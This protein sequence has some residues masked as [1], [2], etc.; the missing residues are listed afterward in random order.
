[1]NTTR[2]IRNHNYRIGTDQLEDGRI[3]AKAR[4]RKTNVRTFPAGT[5]HAEAALALA[6]LI[7][8]ERIAEVREL[9]SV[10][11]KRDYAVFVQNTLADAL[12]AAEPTPADEPAVLPTSYTYGPGD[13][14]EARTRGTHPRLIQMRLT[15]RPRAGRTPQATVITGEHGGNDVVPVVVETDSIRLVDTAPE[16]SPLTPLDLP[17]GSA[18]LARAINELADEAIDGSIR[19]AD[20]YHWQAVLYFFG[21][22]TQEPGAF[23]SKLMDAM[24]SADSGNRAALVRAL[25]A[26]GIPFQFAKEQHHG[27]DAIAEVAAEEERSSVRLGIKALRRTHAR[28]QAG[29]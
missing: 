6:T 28:I 12:A 18:E 25:P 2:S 1:M 11:Y 4:G 7:E 19:R 17:N 3:K 10:G 22:S 21:R 14:V 15:H 9:T 24:A 29:A 26:I 8:G 13:L 20:G 5:T 23:V 27:L 16:W